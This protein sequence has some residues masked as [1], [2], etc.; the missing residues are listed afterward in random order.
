MTEFAVEVRD[1]SKTYMPS[2]PWLRVLLRTQIKEPVVALN[3]VS[4]TVPEGAL[5]VVAGQNGAGK[6]TLFRL[7]VGLVVPTAGSASVLGRDVVDHALAVRS[8]IGFMASDDRTLWLRLSCR[9]NVGFHA[10]QRGIPA[11]QRRGRVDEA[12]RTVGLLDVAERSGFALS[13]GMRA[14][15]QL[16]CA[17]VGRPRV[18]ILDEPTSALDPVAAYE[19]ASLVRSLAEEE[20]IAV[21]ISTHRVDEIEALGQRVL[22][23][24]R[25]EVVHDG[26]IDTLGSAQG[27][28]VELRFASSE[29]A[30]WAR[31][32]LE[33]LPGSTV[34]GSGA[35]VTVTTPAATGRVLASLAH[36]VADL[37]SVSERHQ[38]LRDVLTELLA[39]LE[40]ANQARHGHD[41]HA[42]TDGSL[43]R[44]LRP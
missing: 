21:L 33:D 11:A 43:R 18:L 17:L 41:D 8:A 34:A 16:A 7:L 20:G 42:G 5:T 44:S 36:H 9:E 14:R 4:F 2:S 31:A 23:L 6:S 37:E 27:P 22:L 28:T 15:L 24:H 26:S 25:G 30:S 38:P 29:T 19:M 32:R 1:L 12:L 10:R 40:D 35:V 13:G 3:H 39:G